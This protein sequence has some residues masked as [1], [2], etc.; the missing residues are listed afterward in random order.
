M[1]GGEKAPSGTKFAQ[2]L[3]KKG[4]GDAPGYHMTQVVDRIAR[5]SIKTLVDCAFSNLDTR[6]LCYGKNNNP[7]FEYE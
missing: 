6:E 4:Y 5:I 3:A 7:I 2:R 1:L